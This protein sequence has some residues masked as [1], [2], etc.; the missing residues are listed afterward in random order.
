MQPGAALVQRTQETV[1][2]AETGIG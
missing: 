2:M 1:R